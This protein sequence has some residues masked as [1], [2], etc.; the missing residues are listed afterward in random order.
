MTRGQQSPV[1]ASPV[2]QFGT[3]FALTGKSVYDVNKCYTNSTD[4]KG[5]YER[6]RLKMT[7]S[8][9]AMIEKVVMEVPDYDSVEDF[10][11][12]SALH[13]LMHYQNNGIT[14]N[15]SD[16]KRELHSSEMARMRA[17]MEAQEGYVES[18]K[19]TVDMALEAQDWAQLADII[20]EMEDQAQTGMY[21]TGI[22]NK[23]T[24][25]IEDAW[26]RMASGR[27]SRADRRMITGQD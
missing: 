7:P 14:S 17:R 26:Q 10:L 22:H 4:S 13:R 9:Q 15:E 20:S 21:P 11:R 25:A 12:D 16:M 5:H 24:D 27:S 1:P 19:Q 18:C 2:K 6:S 3:M 8:L 23:L